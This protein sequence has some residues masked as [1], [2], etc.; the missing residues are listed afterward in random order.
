MLLTTTSESKRKHI[1]GHDFQP[2]KNIKISF[3]KEQGFIGVMND[4]EGIPVELHEAENIC[5]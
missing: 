4:G 3:D 1:Q 2:V 5:P